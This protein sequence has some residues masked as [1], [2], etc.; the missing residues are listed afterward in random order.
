MYQQD[1]FVSNLD[2]FGQ[3]YKLVFFHCLQHIIPKFTPF[4]FYPSRKADDRQNMCNAQ[5]VD[6]EL[7]SVP[8][9]HKQ[10]YVFT[11]IRIEGRRQWKRRSK[12]GLDVRD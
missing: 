5:A 3:I 9:N 10:L 6:M 2:K 8:S 1:R 11:S 7:R 12:L 4:L